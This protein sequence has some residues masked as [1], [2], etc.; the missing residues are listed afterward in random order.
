[1]SSQNAIINCALEV[2]FMLKTY[3]EINV[4]TCSYNYLYTLEKPN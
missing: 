2:G 4:D 1:M 3:A